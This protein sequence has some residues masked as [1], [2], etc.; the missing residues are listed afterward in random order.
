MN[1]YTI[2]GEC[3]PDAVIHKIARAPRP[4]PYSERPDPVIPIRKVT[5]SRR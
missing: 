5:I 2:F 1:S 3:T 4:Q